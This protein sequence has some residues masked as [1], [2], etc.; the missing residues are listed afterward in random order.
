MSNLKIKKILCA[1]DFSEESKKALEFSLTLASE[2]EE[3]KLV[4]IT[5]LR[6][7]PTPTGDLTGAFESIMQ[8]N[9]SALKQISEKLTTFVNESKG[10]YP[11]LVEEK[12]VLG[13]AAEQILDEVSKEHPDMVVMG[14]KKHGFKRGILAGSVSERVSANS[15]VSVL[16]VR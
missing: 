4:V 5:V 13:M 10:S 11:S 9:E 15:T 6:P 1:V 8:D 3:C 14:N 2:I 16:I 12:A 7:M